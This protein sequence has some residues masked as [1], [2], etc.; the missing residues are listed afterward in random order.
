MKAQRILDKGMIDQEGDRQ[1]EEKSKDNNSQ[2]TK[3]CM[4]VFDWGA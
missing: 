2:S 1:S 3:V 4:V